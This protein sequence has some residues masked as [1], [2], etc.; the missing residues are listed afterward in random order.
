MKSP[1]ELS[2]ALQRQWENPQLR[3]ARLLG[4]AEWPLRLSI[5]RPSGKMMAA[6][7]HD[8]AQHIKEWRAVRAGQ[9]IWESV[10]FRAAGDEVSIPVAWEIADVSDWIECAAS[11][12]VSRES[13]SLARLIAETDPLF[14]SLFI[15]QRS[16]WNGKALEEILK[17]AQLASR[18]QPSCAAGAPLRAISLAGIDSK[19]FERHRGLILRLLDLRFDG[20]PSRQGLE[21]FLNAWQETDHWLLVVD[22]EGT[23]LPFAEQRVRSSEL[24]NIELKV[25]HLLIVE[26]ER[27]LHLLPRPLPQTIAVLGTGNNLAWLTARWVQR[28]QVAY[29]GDIDTWGLSLLAHARSLVPKLTALL[30]SQTEFEKYAP[31]HAVAEAI[32]ARDHPPDQLTP[33][34][35]TLYTHLL[36]CEQG[37]MEQEFFEKTD[38]EA[39][40]SRWLSPSPDQ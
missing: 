32:V 9:V 38:V 28:A 7:W 35:K 14:H 16:L 17:A 36:S 12:A 29:W 10:T 15:R 25:E 18:L 3:D 33:A 39:A 34:E 40:L 1:K 23:I 13:S 22:L 37:R 8:V 6:H 19:F 24:R 21:T 26:N 11:R 20:E 27:C 5:G 4:D 31:A 2:Q 30:M